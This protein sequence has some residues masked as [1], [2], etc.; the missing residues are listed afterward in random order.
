MEG[1]ILYVDIWQ[2]L[3]AEKNMVFLAGPRQCGKTTLTEIISESFT[4]KIYFNS[5]ISG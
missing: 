1:R 5:L 4:N 3:A 2:E